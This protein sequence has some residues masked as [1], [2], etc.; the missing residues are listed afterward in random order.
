M[1]F[2]SLATV[3]TFCN[4]LRTIG[5]AAAL[6]VSSGW[7]ISSAHAGSVRTITDLVSISFFER[8][9]GVA[10]TEY[11]FGVNSAQLTTRLNDPLSGSN[12]DFGGVPTEF[13]DVYYS[14][15]NGG[16]D[17]DGE[18]LTISGVFGQALPFGGGL[19][20]AEIGLNFGSTPVEFG[21]FV[22][23]YQTLG[24]NAALGG[25]VANAIDGDLQ[26][27][28]TLGNTVGL[29]GE[30][31]RVTLGFLSSSGEPPTVVPVPAALP[32]FLSGLIGLGVM[33][34]RRNKKIA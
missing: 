31:L 6:L 12:N 29:T 15:A 27:H 10:P 18:Y 9:G 3:G 22:A 17:I 20:L 8:S 30:R 26:T 16:F 33:A 24:N 34:R 23:S 7:M 25:A 28:T 13:Y 5:V 14:G 32:L 21:N 11:T 2:N 19:N 4:N 1:K